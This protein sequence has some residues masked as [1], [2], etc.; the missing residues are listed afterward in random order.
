MWT[1][2]WS[3]QLKSVAADCLGKR[4]RAQLRAGMR[5]RGCGGLTVHNTSSVKDGLRDNFTNAVYLYVI[6]NTINQGLTF[7]NC[8]PSY[9][10]T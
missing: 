9:H 6:K 5:S 4:L 10:P 3:A 8:R 7:M 2:T 1:P